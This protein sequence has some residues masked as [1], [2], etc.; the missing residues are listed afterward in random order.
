MHCLK[1]AFTHDNRLSGLKTHDWHK[2]LQ[3]ILPITIKGCLTPEIRQV[4]YKISRLVCWISQKEIL[5][6]SIEENLINAIEAMCLLEKNFPSSAMT[7]QVHL[8]VH[9]VDEVT[10]LD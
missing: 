4:I 9:I 5:H 6:E 2:M 3:Y 8:L 1:G 10:L 7:I